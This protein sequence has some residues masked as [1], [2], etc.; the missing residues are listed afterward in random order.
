MIIVIVNIIN[1]TK[2]TPMYNFPPSTV[3]VTTMYKS[4]TLNNTKH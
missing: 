4:T 3:K 1:C 2:E